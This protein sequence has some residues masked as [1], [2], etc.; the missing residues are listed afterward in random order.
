MLAR[1]ETFV[2]LLVGT[3][4]RVIVCLTIRMWL[5]SLV[6]NVATGS[7]NQVKIVIVEAQ[8][9]VATIRAAT[10]EHASLRTMPFVM[11]PTRIA[12][13]IASFPAPDQYVGLALVNVIRRK[14][15]PVQLLPARPMSLLRMVTAAETAPRICSVQADNARRGISSARH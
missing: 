13:I 9:I 7:S 15:A 4:S 8:R 10:Q 5:R 1:L 3:A 11:T 6:N 14:L 12:V 2:P